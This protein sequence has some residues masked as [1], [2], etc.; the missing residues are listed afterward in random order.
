[1]S[2]L[3]NLAGLFP[4]EIGDPWITGNVIPE[5]NI[6]W[7]PIP[8]HS[9]PLSDDTLLTGIQYS[10]TFIYSIHGLVTKEI[11][12]VTGKVEILHFAK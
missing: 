9:V 6:R 3:S 11:V 5:E 7:R 2:A 10:M 8:V 1:M 12:Y 4:P